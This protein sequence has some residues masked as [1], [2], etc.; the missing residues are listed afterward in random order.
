MSTAVITGSENWRVKLYQL[1]S[2]GTWLDQG[3]GYVTCKNL[4]NLG[5]T[6]VV[7]MREDDSSL[8]LQS[9]ILQDDVY[10]RQGESIIMWREIGE[11]TMD[12]DY[13]LSFQDVP[14][15]QTIW[16]KILEIRSQSPSLLLHD[17]SFMQRNSSDDSMYSSS[18]LPPVKATNLED[19]RLRLLS[20]HPFQRDGYILYLLERNCEYL[21]QLFHLFTE[22]EES[23]NLPQLKMLA[24][25]FR[26]ILLLNDSS[27]IEFLIQEDMFL[28]L[29][30]V[31]EFDPHLGAPAEH[32]KFL[33]GKA[34][35]KEVVPLPDE[36]LR[37]L[38][39][40]LFRLRYLRD[41][42]LRPM[43]DETGVTAL[44]SMLMFTTA[45]ICSR[46]FDDY[47]LLKT[48]LEICTANATPLRQLQQQSMLPPGVKTAA[49]PASP[50]ASQT[51]SPDS[52]VSSATP[53]LSPVLDGNALASVAVESITTGQQRVIQSASSEEVL[54][55]LRELFFLSRSLGV[56]RRG[57]MYG[58][59][60][61]RADLRTLFF[62]AMR[63][64]LSD[65]TSTA[66][67]RIYTAEC[68][69]CLTLVCPG[70]LRADIVEAPLP[71]APPFMAGS[72]T[73]STKASGLKEPLSAVSLNNVNERSLLWVII[74]H[75]VNDSESAV[76]EQ[77][78]DVLKVMLD[79][80]RMDRVEKERFLALFYDH[81][82]L[83][84]IEPFAVEGTPVDAPLPI[85]HLTLGVSG[86]REVQG[87][88]ALST[89]RR[90]LCEILSLCVQGH[91]YR[92]RYFV[93]R[94]SVLSRVLKLLGSKH[95]HLHVYALRVVR[96]MLTVKDEH[97][98]RHIVK[99][100]LLGP[101]LQELKQFC[102]KD[103]LLTSAIIELV[104]Y[105]RTEGIGV[106]IENI[107]EKHSDCLEDVLHVDT[108]DK[109]RLRFDQMNDPSAL[110][111][112][113][114]TAATDDNS[115]Q[116]DKRVRR[117]NRRNRQLVEQE[118]EE[119]YFDDDQDGAVA[120]PS[121]SGEAEHSPSPESEGCPV[122]ASVPTTSSLDAGFESMPESTQP[123]S[124]GNGSASKYFGSFGLVSS[125]LPL[126][127]E[128]V[129]LGPCNS[130][131]MLGS[132]Y[133]DDEEEEDSSDPI[134]SNPGSANT[135]VNSTP[136]T[137]SLSLRQS[138]EA[139]GS[140]SEP[141]L[142]PLRPKFESDD[143]DD[144]PFLSAARIASVFGG[145]PMKR[146][147][148]SVHSEPSH[149]GDRVS[150][151]GA[152]SASQSRDSMEGSAGVRF[153]LGSSKKQ[154]KL[155]T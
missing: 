26:L 70:F 139:P 124:V 29:A 110:D 63:A 92:M 75:V 54:G 12:V 119:A 37:R 137:S 112:S 103:N 141:P 146:S 132:L 118:K 120:T 102:K 15:C 100:D 52:T 111:T 109:L 88:S 61:Q 98:Y 82:V 14:G 30:G 81:Y 151:S 74:H 72:S 113:A 65:P 80:E 5:G 123:S 91:H 107:V 101:I 9:K 129:P 136:P 71:S 23:D 84:L 59:M 154:K 99:Y 58:R 6:A 40:Q 134:A 28:N 96:S 104:E 145:S 128:R 43:L 140:G 4:P 42:M 116:I 73:G 138:E 130:L 135:F 27:L 152:I 90:F 20:L 10:E 66:N 144:I 143:D 1:E 18:S 95:R 78:G 149:S 153:T 106:L 2:E 115:C 45:E 89:S 93:M 77:L 122:P 142:P 48:L 67:A 17:T 13:A 60:M 83:W 41:Y 148:P 64:V 56:D 39:T 55:F 25:I 85:S 79:P 16:N 147:R 127:L 62:A 21:K 22:L 46:V 50:C 51:S 94:N 57:E 11:N 97:Y 68:L 31:M 133:G 87:P 131:A 38:I 76:I 114:R 125:A 108:Y 8:L 69:A 47:H 36:E 53:S 32:R 117:A 49:P 35:L 155:T 19:L 44:T 33:S 150:S 126:P 121:D 86:K 34:R 24:E 7:V 3:T 105:I